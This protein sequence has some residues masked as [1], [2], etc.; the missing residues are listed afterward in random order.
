VQAARP[1]QRREIERFGFGLA[2][3]LDAVEGFERG[4]Q[5]G[6]DRPQ[7]PHFGSKFVLGLRAYVTHIVADGR[8]D[9]GR[10]K[11]TLD[12]MRSSITADR[13][14]GIVSSLRRGGSGSGCGMLRVQ[15]SKGCS[16]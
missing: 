15:C 9:G 2:G 14:T 4:L 11:F 7:L 1:R 5:L 10:N 6:H 13:S 8:A 12:A 3:V 16:P